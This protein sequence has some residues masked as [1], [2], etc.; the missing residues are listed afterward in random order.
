ML[1]LP[2]STLPCSSSL[3]V[4]CANTYFFKS[5]LKFKLKVAISQRLDIL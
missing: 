2:F 3:C 4:L 1:H 5:P